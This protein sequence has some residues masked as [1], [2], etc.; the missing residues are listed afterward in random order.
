[1]LNPCTPNSSVKQAYYV[2]TSFLNV[3]NPSLFKE[4]ETSNSL[5]MQMEYAAYRDKHVCLPAEERNDWA[6]NMQEFIWSK[7]PPSSGPYQYDYDDP[8]Y[9]KMKEIFGRHKLSCRQF[10]EQSEKQIFEDNNQEPMDKSLLPL[11]ISLWSKVNI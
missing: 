6:M 1:M 11:L 9:M 4:V 7:F 2:D 5:K 10:R 3:S 8:R